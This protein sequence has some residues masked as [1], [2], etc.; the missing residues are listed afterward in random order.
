MAKMTDFRTA[1]DD[2]F[3]DA[4]AKGKPYVDVL[5]RDLHDVVMNG[6]AGNRMPMACNAMHGAVRSG[7]EILETSPSGQTSRLRIRYRLPR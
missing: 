6:E 4:Q 2:Y 5:S 1:L 7:D 3:R